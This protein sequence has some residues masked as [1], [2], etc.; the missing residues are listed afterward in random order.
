[1]HI[2]AM[3]HKQLQEGYSHYS[4]VIPQQGQSM[5]PQKYTD[6]LQNNKNVVPASVYV[7]A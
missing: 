5:I 2:A 3:L 1:M 4:V 6:G 7:T